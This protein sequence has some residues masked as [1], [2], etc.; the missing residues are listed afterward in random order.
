MQGFSQRPGI[1]YKETYAPVMDAITF[2]F[3]ISLVITENLDMRLMNV[4]TAN[5]YGSLNND[6]YMKISEGYKMLATYGSM[7]QSMYSIKIQRFLYGLNQFGPMWYNHLNKYLLKEGFVNNPICT[8]VFIKNSESKFAIVA[9]YVN[10]FKSCSG[11]RRAQKNHKW[12]KNKFEMKDLGMTKICLW[13]QYE[14]LP[15]GIL[16]H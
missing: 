14:H 5:L 15:N 10:D 11:S 3:L 6:I 4:V 12:L 2:K 1:Y 8:C 13:L 9:V 16:V 7:S